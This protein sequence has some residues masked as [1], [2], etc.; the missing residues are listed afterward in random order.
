MLGKFLGMRRAVIIWMCV[1]VFSYTHLAYAEMTS[2]DYI[3][4]W[5]SINS[6]GSD[7]AT[8]STFQLRDSLGDVAPG[9]STSTSF[10]TN[11]GYRAGVNDQ[12]ITFQVLGQNNATSRAATALSGQTITTSTT[13][14]SVGNFVALIQDRGA[15]QVSAVGKII[16]IGAGT[17]TLDELKDGGT[18][19]V[20]DGTNDFVVVLSSTSAALGALSSSSVT[21]S[22]IGMDVTAEVDGGYTVQV[23]DDGDLR[24]GANVIAN[25]SDGSVTAGSEEYGGRSSDTSIAASTFDTQDTAFSTSFQDIADRSGPSFASRDFL[26]LKA[27]ISPTT[28]NG[29]YAQTLS[30]IVSGNY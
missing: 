7:T 11:A 14:L 1:G 6:G 21:T 18:A 3:V 30:I 13:G 23:A 27:S 4:R 5:D 29:S 15:A 2:S 28:V 24:S 16:S 26:T 22:I 10:Q 8:S 17:I 19:P 20:I 9:G 12:V 25:V